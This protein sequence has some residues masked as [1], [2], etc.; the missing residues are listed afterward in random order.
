[1]DDSVT[2]LYPNQTERA[3]QSRIEKRTNF[4]TT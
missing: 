1:M 3:H 4:F 2:E